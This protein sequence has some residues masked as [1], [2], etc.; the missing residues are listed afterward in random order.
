M[1][2]GAAAALLAVSLVLGA[3]AGDDAPTSGVASTTTVEETTT[4]PAASPPSPPAPAVTFPRAR[5][6]SVPQGFRAEV[7]ATGLSRPTAMAYGPDGRLYVT[8]E[9]GE[10]V[11][12]RPRSRRP[13]VVASGFPTPLG[14]AWQGRTLFVSAQGR[15]ER[16]RL[17]GSRLAGR[18]AILTDLPYGRHQQDNVVLGPDGRLYLG[19]GSTCDVCREDDPRSATVL[20][21]RPDG[22]DLRV[23]A[24]GLR[25][26]FGLAFQPETDRLY[27][28]VNGQDNLPDPSSPEP[29]EMLVRIRPGAH[30]GWPR[31][32][33]SA[34]RQRMMGNCAGVTPPAAYLETHSSANG[35]AF[36]TGSTFPERFGDGV[37]VALWGQYTSEAHGRRVDFVAL[38]ADGTSPGGGVRTFADG[39]DHPLALAVDPH[40]A[41]LVADWGRG[42][43]YRI[44]ARGAP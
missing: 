31:C 10:V 23:V 43:I 18:Q 22:G 42:A 21:L 41:L 3:C 26:P 32:W 1:R 25:N 20:S 28:S 30:Y 37:F 24:R 14:L 40:G 19:S 7:F 33:P 34:R 39:F 27:A 11:V 9:T 13:R 8:Q 36:Y 2:L 17:R 38:E 12:V 4:V 5:R 6:I 29:A 16:L 35:L 15:L 44:Q